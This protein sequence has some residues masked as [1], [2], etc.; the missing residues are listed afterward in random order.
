MFQVTAAATAMATENKWYFRCLGADVM[1]LMVPVL[2]C[3]WTFWARN[4]KHSLWKRKQFVDEEC[5]FSASAMICYWWWWLFY[6]VFLLFPQMVTRTKKIFVGGL[7][8][9]TTL[10]DVKSYF[11][12][13]GPVSATHSQFRILK[14]Q[15]ENDK[16]PFS[17]RRRQNKCMQRRCAQFTRFPYLSTIK[18]K[19]YII[20][21]LT[22]VN[23]FVRGSGQ[24]RRTQHE[25]KLT[26]NRLASHKIY[27][28][29]III[30]SN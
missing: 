29:K 17:W 4:F 9:P 28:D 15:I 19:G 12:Q 25:V 1:W 14:F 3:R 6:P 10:E 20:F 22:F 16:K 7:S 2:R 18:F 30:T 8:A 27:Y 13:F 23:F 21:S 11:E 24:Y 5:E 26:I